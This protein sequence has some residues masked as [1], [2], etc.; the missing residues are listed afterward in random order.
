MSPRPPRQVPPPPGGAARTSTYSR[1]IPREE[2][3]EFSAW[4][5]DTFEGGPAPQRPS[6]SAPTPAPPPEPEVVPEPEPDIDELLHAARQSGYQDGYRDG[7]AALDAF[8]QSFAT[9]MSAQIGELVKGFDAEF[10]GLEQEMAQALLRTAVALARQVVQ[11]EIEQNP[12][13]IAR[14]ADE[15]VD[16]LLVSARHIRVRVN[17]EDLPLVQEGAGD[18]LQAREAQLLPDAS[19]ERG[20]CKVESDISSVDA[21]VAAR[22][23]QAAATLG[24]SA[25]WDAPQDMHDGGLKEA[26]GGRQGTDHD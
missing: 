20:G 4:N 8:K 19:I 26:P 17:P 3:Q 23:R 25:L 2:L 6:V 1:F 24:Q 15:A 7:M 12:A 10:Q 11:T 13:L 14:V 18:K 9:Q 21:T 22:W 5:P 16:A